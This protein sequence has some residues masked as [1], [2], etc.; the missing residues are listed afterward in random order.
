MFDA[1]AGAFLLPLSGAA[2]VAGIVTGLSSNLIC[3]VQ[4]PKGARAWE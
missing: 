3:T 2:V 4:L 1:A